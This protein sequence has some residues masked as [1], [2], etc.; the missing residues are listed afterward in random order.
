MQIIPASSGIQSLTALNPAQ[1]GRLLTALD[2][3]RRE[4]DYLLID[5]AAG[6]S[7]NVLAHAGA[8]GPRDRW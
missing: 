6:I 1:R 5:T 4:L 7:D 2:E 8:G 3:A